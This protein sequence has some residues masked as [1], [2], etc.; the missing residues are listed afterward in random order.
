M[1]PKGVEQI[2]TSPTESAERTSSP[3]QEVYRRARELVTSQPE[4]FAVRGASN[5]YSAIIVAHTRLTT[6]QGEQYDISVSVRKIKGTGEV[7]ESI[8]FGSP[9]RG[10]RAVYRLDVTRGAEA[11]K[12]YREL[13]K[14]AQESA[15]GGSDKTHQVLTSLLSTNFDVSGDIPVRFSDTYAETR[16]TAKE[17]LRI[18]NSAAKLEVPQEMAHYP[19]LDK[20]LREAGRPQGR[21]LPQ[22]LTEGR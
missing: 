21:S 22:L 15:E 2:A 19:R 7:E 6:T 3:I 13:Q 16:I 12:L 11:Q 9:E 10:N 4:S 1:A 14:A 17:V 20:L 8:C 18:L 5:E